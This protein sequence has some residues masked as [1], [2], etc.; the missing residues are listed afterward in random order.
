MSKMLWLQRLKLRM[1]AQQ[2]GLA[3]NGIPTGFS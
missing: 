1:A 3:E 2:N